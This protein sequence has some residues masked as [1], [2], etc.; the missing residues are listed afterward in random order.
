MADIGIEWV[1]Q[2]HGRANNLSNTQAQA[3]GLYNTLSGVRR[4]NWGD[5]LAWDQDFE[6]T[7]AGSPATGTDNTWIDTVDIAFFSGH[8]S[9]SGPF[10]GIA[11]RDDGTAKPTELQLGNNN[12]EWLT[13]DAC[14]VLNWDNGNVFSRW[15]W[16]VFKG[17]HYILGFHT[18]TR[19]ESKRG[20][21]LAENLNNGD[22]VRDAWR[23]ACQE[24]E[25]SSTQ[26]AY[27]RADGSGTN[28]FDDHWWGKGFVSPDPSAPNVLFYLRDSC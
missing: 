10:F 19:D 20:R 9:T 16:P 4:F 6:Q 2:Y 28:T 3:E 25:D 14:E 22:R 5:D 24:T 26:Y 7:G 15:G 27:L 17:L 13:L 21:Y 12:L 23:K 18:T 1:K 11:S 8:G